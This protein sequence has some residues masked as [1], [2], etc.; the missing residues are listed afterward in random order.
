V[1]SPDIKM[2]GTLVV[3]G[4]GLLIAGYI[5]YELRAFLILLYAGAANCRTFEDVLAMLLIVAFGVIVVG[6]YAIFGL[7]KAVLGV[8]VSPAASVYIHLLP[9]LLMSGIF[10]TRVIALAVDRSRASAGLW[11]KSTFPAHQIAVLVVV[12]TLDV[13][14]YTFRQMAPGVVPWS[15]SPWPGF[16]GV[17]AVVTLFTWL[18]AG[19]CVA[20]APRP[21]EGDLQA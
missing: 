16:W 17:C 1:E 6:D 2:I 21:V 18:L 14:D 5:L 15:S 9:H 20:L 3:G 4:L 7:A 11:S 19:L 12:G 10:L 8:D 13:G